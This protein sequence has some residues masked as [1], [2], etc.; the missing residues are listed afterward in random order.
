MSAPESD[1][2]TVTSINLGIL[3]LHLVSGE[4]VI[5][6]V[7]KKIDPTTG[8]ESYVVA[9]PVIPNIAMSQDPNTGQPKFRVGLLP[10][11]PYLGNLP[12]VEFATAYVMYIVRVNPQMEA[13]YTE[14][15]TGIAIVPANAL[16]S[17]GTIKL[18]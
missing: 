11:R 8:G 3:D 9:K 14:F 16:P 7:T 18:A 17:E 12:E 5:G 15:T 2:L 13:M 10:L 1:G 6:Q 4:D